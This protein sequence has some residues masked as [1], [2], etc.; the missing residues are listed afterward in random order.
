MVKLTVGA[1]GL[2]R[3]AELIISSGLARL[4][5]ACLKAFRH[6]Q[7]LPATLDGKPVDGTIELPANWR[8]N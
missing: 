1:D 4:D 7:F 2:V 5:Q 6:A 8:L 3:H